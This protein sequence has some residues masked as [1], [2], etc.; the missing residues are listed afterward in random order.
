MSTDHKVASP[1]LP[2]DA[3][4]LDRL[5]EEAGLDLLLVTSKH[6]VQYLSLS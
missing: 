6:N 2:F 3:D 4:K 1:Q 5:M